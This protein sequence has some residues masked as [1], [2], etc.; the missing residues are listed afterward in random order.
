MNMQRCE[1]RLTVSM[2]DFDKLESILADYKAFCKGSDSIDHNL[3]LHVNLAGF[4]DEGLKI[5][6]HVGF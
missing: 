3:P 4:D 6:V 1:K 2:Q 5:A